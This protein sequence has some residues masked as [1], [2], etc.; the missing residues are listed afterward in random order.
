MKFYLSALVLGNFTS[1]KGK[2]KGLAEKNHNK[3]PAPMTSGRQ[4]TRE[5]G[6]SGPTHT[7]HGHFFSFPSCIFFLT[8]LFK[9]TYC[10]SYVT[11]SLLACKSV[12]TRSPSSLN[13]LA[14]IA[15]RL[16][17]FLGGVVSCARR[18]KK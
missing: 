17:F 5:N 14:I 18:K 10:C 15:T 8:G 6:N 7:L 2:K 13:Y 9:Y 3:R 16:N 11:S 12:V 1:G 4:E